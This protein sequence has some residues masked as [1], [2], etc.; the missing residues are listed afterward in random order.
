MI[1]PPVPTL[2]TLTIVCSARASPAAHKL[3]VFR[4]SKGADGCRSSPTQY[5]FCKQV[6]ISYA[7]ELTDPRG[8]PLQLVHRDISPPNVLVTKYG[9]VKIVDFGL[10]K[11]SSQLEDDGGGRA[12]A[13]AA[14]DRPARATDPAPSTRGR[15]RRSRAAARR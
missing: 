1:L 3:R 7:H 6:A 5:S 12:A 15:A 4:F 10:A 9:E 8:M 2:P 14:S 11:A 13:A